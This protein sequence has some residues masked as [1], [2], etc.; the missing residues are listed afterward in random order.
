MKQRMKKKRQT[1]SE[2][3]VGLKRK[4]RLRRARKWLASYFGEDVF[5][6]FRSRYAVDEICA[7]IELQ[8]LG[9]VHPRVEQLCRRVASRQEN[10]RLRKA[11][12]RADGRAEALLPDS[13]ENFAYIAGYTSGGAS[14]GVTWEEWERMDHD[15]L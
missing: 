2:R 15:A 8:Q 5:C 12:Q 9:V 6:D 11:E 7:A 14:Y 13:D 10:R 1:S 4:T 3:Q